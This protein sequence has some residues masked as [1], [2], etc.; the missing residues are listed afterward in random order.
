[1]HP[2]IVGIDPGTTSAF[3]VLSFDFKVIAIKSKKE[4]SLGGIIQDIYRYGNPILVGTDKKEIPSFIKEFS[5]KT[6]AKI[7][8][9][10]YDTKKGEKLFIVKEKRF[11]DLVKNTHETDALASAIYAYNEYL[12]LIKKVNSFVE[13]NNK[14]ELK[15]KL[16]IKV[17][18][19]NKNIIE[20]VT[21]LETIPVKK[22]AKVIEYPHTEKKEPT[23]EEKEITWLREF[24]QKLKDEIRDLKEENDFLKQKKIDIT[25]VTRKTLS[26]KENRAL[27]LEK[28]NRNLKKEIEQKNNI[29]KKLDSF[30]SEC[31]N[32]V[33]LKKLKNLGSEEYT[34]KKDL[35]K[36]SKEDNLLVEDISIMSENVLCDLKENVKVIIYVKGLN[37]EVS[38][39]FVLFEK[40]KF[41]LFE[42]K[43]F[44]LVN[45]DKFE[46]EVE[47]ANKKK[48]PFSIKEI[49]EEYKRERK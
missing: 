21:E 15:D 26:F 19:E 13:K 44:A 28:E 22:L 33:L 24:T 23:H 30:I 34:A 32:N 14:E 9:P 12:Q 1:M 41:D 38:Q 5:Q 16:L 10:K 18:T 3:A 11:I 27:S 29:I 2:V 37:K 17:I 36:I 46:K 35:L 47:K 45:K 49:L 39:N 42:T 43:H 4:Y 20:A 31:K 48:E 7:Y 8:S 6:G 40:N 25:K